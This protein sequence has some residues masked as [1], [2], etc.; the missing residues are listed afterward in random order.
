MSF[1]EYR[2]IKDEKKQEA[3]QQY[4]IKNIARLDKP[5]Y[6]TVSARVWTNN[7]D[8]YRQKREKDQKEA[9]ILHDFKVKRGDF[10]DDPPPTPFVAA[11]K[12][13]SQMI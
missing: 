7:E 8:F 13:Q 12:R 11:P 9:K 6:Q 4:S 10:G 3:K 5:D 1:E 2:K